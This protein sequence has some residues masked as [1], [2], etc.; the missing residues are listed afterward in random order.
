MRSATFRRASI[1]ARS[2]SRSANAPSDNPDV[3]LVHRFLAAP[4]TPVAVNSNALARALGAS[5]TGFDPATRTLAMR[6]VP[7]PLFR[8]GAGV[9]QGG[10]LAAML[11]F[12]MAFAG[13]ATVDATIGLSTVTLNVVLQRPAVADAYEAVGRIDKA[14]RRAM[15]ASAEIRAG[16]SVVATATSTLLV[17]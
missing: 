11:D 6:Y 3:V 16:S 7:E 12:A 14:G 4:D 17:V 15:F 13:M 10:A 9:V 5:L 8:Q 1:S 2:V